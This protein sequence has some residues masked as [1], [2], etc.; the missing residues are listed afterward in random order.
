MKED[1]ELIKVVE[2][3]N[4]V[5]LCPVLPNGLEFGSVA[6]ASS[7]DEAKKIIKEAVEREGWEVEEDKMVLQEIDTT[8]AN[9]VIIDPLNS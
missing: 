8:Y 5:Y 6:V 4:K 9:A 3:A 7:K 1:N 2:F